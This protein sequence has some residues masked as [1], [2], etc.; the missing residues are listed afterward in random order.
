[1]EG[2]LA[3]ST[4]REYCDCTYDYLVDRKGEEYIVK[5]GFEVLDEDVS[6]DVA[7]LMMDAIY[8]CVDLL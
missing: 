2:C 7:D 6:A 4:S 1:M 5:M 8:S 3:E